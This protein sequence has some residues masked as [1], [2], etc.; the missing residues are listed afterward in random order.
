M[1]QK[2]PHAVALGKRG[3]TANTPA[4]NAARAAN[5][6]LGGRPRKPRPE[7]DDTRSVHAAAKTKR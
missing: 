6:R 1:A 2:N 7:T 5:G 4:Q 3:G